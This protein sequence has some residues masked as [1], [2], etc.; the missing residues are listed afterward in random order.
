MDQELRVGKV[1]EMEASFGSQ[2]KDYLSLLGGGGLGAA[3]RAPKVAVSLAQLSKQKKMAD[4]LRAAWDP[5]EN[6]F[7]TGMK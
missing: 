4:A 3:A 5:A 1:P 2:V 6:I 7:M